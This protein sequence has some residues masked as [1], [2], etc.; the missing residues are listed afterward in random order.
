MVLAI[1]AVFVA[2]CSSGSTKQ[3]VAPGSSEPASTGIFGYFAQ[4]ASSALF[5]QMTQRDTD[6]SGTVTVARVAGAGTSTTVDHKSASFT[7]FVAGQD[8]SLT[9]A[10]G[11]GLSTT[12]TGKLTADQFVVTYNASDGRLTELSLQR[13]PIETYN[14]AVEALE[15]QAASQASDAQQLAD[16]QSAASSDAKRLAQVDRERTSIANYA[17]S[18]LADLKSVED[19]LAEV[20]RQAAVEPMD[21]FQAQSVQFAADS[22]GFSR[23]S[24]RFSVDAVDQAL[25]RLQAIADQA[26]LDEVQA[27]VDAAHSTLDTA[28]GLVDEA[29]SIARDAKQRAGDG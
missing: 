28:N 14:A 20:R 8:V 25:S 17:A 23:D 2:A 24:V 1:A 12:W 21:S 9:F 29:E 27:Q 13:K 26:T 4:D 19:G 5:L 6:V 15:R 11:F 22:V 18:A 3:G 10:Q 7:G 16:Q